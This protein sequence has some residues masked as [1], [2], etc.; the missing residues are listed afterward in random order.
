MI[1][2]RDS[3]YDVN[4]LVLADLV[5]KITVPVVLYGSELIDDTQ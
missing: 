2:I 4:P 3:Q 5:Q 1:I